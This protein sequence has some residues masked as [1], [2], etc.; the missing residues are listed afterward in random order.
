[1][2]LLTLFFSMFDDPRPWITAGLTI[3]GPA[4]GFL[5]FLWFFRVIRLIVKKNITCPEEK[6]RAML[7]FTTQVGE[8]GPYRD[9]ISCSLQNGQKAIACGKGCLSSPAV[10]EAPFISIQR[11]DI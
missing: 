6:R 7:D 4:I 5:I 10:V 3:T 2:D 1:M 9:V 8:L 11:R